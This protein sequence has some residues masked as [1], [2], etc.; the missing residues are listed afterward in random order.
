MIPGS[1]FTGLVSGGVCAVITRTING[2]R[3]SAFA[4]PG[5]PH[6]AAKWTCSK[7]VVLADG[8]VT[9]WTAPKQTP[10]AN[11]ADLEDLDYA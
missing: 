2:V 9:T 5:T 7:T 6:T 10:G 11:G 1:A 3:Y 8:E 4:D